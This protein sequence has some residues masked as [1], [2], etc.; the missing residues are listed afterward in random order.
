VFNSSP[1]DPAIDPLKAALLRPFY[2]AFFFALLLFFSAYILF[3]PQAIRD[4]FLL[5]P[6]LLDGEA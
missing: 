2:Q 4:L 6:L 5:S 3:S 1:V